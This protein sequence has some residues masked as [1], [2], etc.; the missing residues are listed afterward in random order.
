ML[1]HNWS[2]RVGGAPLDI[3]QTEKETNEFWGSLILEHPQKGFGES[4]GVGAPCRVRLRHHLHNA[5]VTKASM[6]A[7]Q[8]LLWD[9]SNERF[10]PRFPLN[11]TPQGHPAKTSSLREK[12]SPDLYPKPIRIRSANLPE[13][14][15]LDSRSVSNFGTHE[16]SLSLRPLIVLSQRLN[17]TR[18]SL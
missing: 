14:A 15:D 1:S 13:S 11:H 5:C 6:A 16:R 17:A 4:W 10:P 2:L 7:R 9:P 12:H 18:C 3:R 8:G